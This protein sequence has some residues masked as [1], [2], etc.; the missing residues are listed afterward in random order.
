MEQLLYII[1]LLLSVATAC[2]QVIQGLK[3]SDTEFRGNWYNLSPDQYGNSL[4][5]NQ[6]PK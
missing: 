6:P 1:F 2:V 3:M 4:A 5:G